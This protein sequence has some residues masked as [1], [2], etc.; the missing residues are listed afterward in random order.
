MSSLLSL[1]GTPEPPHL[2]MQPRASTKSL[3]ELNSQLDAIFANDAMD[4]HHRDLCRAAVLL[5]HD[6]FEAAHNLAQEVE[7]PNGS[8]LHGILHRREPDF[9]NARYWFRRVGATHPS[10]DCVVGK[11]KIA[12]RGAGDESFAKL[13]IANGKWHP[14]GFVD[15]LE[16]AQLRPDP[17]R[18]KLWRQIQAAEIHCFLATLLPRADSILS[19]TTL[20]PP[21]V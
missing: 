2:T 12:L 19:K 15:L 14:L 3:G 6:H 7:G 11:I 5:W 17:S 10:F 16:D 18:D 1:L 20:G 21:S 9:S 8:L 4:R 13:M